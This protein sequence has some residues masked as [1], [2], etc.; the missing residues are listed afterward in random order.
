MD[1]SE[2]EIAS[3]MIEKEIEAGVHRVRN[4]LRTIPQRSDRSC[5]MCC[6]RIPENRAALGFATCVP[7]QTK[8]ELHR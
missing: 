1:E 4:N 2:F 5:V 6:E 3:R 7:C 8:R